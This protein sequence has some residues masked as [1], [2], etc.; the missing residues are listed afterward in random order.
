MLRRI[1][2]ASVALCALTLAATHGGA[3]A[4][5]SVS[6]GRFSCTVTAA[7]ATLSRTSLTAKASITC[8]AATTA[9]VYVGISEMDGTIEQT[10][11]TPR[12]MS[13]A[14]TRANTAVAITGPTV[15]CLNTET[16]NEEYA[17]KV[18]VV[19]T[20]STGAQVSSAWDL[21]IPANDAYAC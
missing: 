21:K 9:A 20:T 13:I 7:A 11:Q 19:L 4:A 12:L 3:A 2:A 1:V 10:V 14:V 17:S 16:G 5:A 18:Q 6:N 8:T 15:T